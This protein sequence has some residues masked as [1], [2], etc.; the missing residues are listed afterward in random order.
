MP[1]RHFAR[2]AS[3]LEGVAGPL[4]V[5]T[6]LALLVTFASVHANAETPSPCTHCAEWNVSQ[7]PSTACRRLADTSRANLEKRVASERAQGH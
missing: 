1:V 6:L 5:P 7:E 3:R 2:V 4:R